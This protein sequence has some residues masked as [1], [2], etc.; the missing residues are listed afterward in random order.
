MRKL[1]ILICVLMAATAAMAQS[2][3]RF[4]VRVG[5]GITNFW[6]KDAPHGVQA[7][8]QAGAFLEYR[9]SNAFS[10]S[11][12]V[13]FSSQGGKCT[14]YYVGGP[15]SEGKQTHATNYITVPV[16]LKIYA[17]PSL[18]VDFGPQVGFNVYSKY[19]R[20]LGDKKNTVDIK[21]R[22]N[23][24]DIGLGLGATYYIADDYFLQLRY[25]MGLTKVFK[26]PSTA[27]GEPMTNYFD[28]GDA[29][30]SVLMLSVGYR[31]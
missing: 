29:K 14:V 25:T 8:Y 28:I 31:F 16:M 13:L 12:E 26:D 2:N 7:N 22:T 11:P 3:L 17:I 30:N 15:I 27:A 18:S 23:K 6:G 19:T 24:V 10:I 5:N 1:T 20:K 21:D 4:G 9:V